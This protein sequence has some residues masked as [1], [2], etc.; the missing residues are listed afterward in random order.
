MDIDIDIDPLADL[1][2]MNFVRASMIENDKIKQHPVGVYFQSIPIDMDSGLAAIPYRHA[3]EYGFIKIDLLNLNL[4]KNFESRKE[5]LAVLNIKPDWTLLQD[6]TIVKRLFHIKNHF[7]LV[8]KCKPQSVEDL[9][10]I[11][12]LIRP[13]KIKFIDKYLKSKKEIRKF[14]YDKIDD[15]DLRKS[16][17]IAYALNIVLQINLIKLGA[18]I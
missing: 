18:D 8:S 16:H 13:N 3:Q 7:D 9:A 12:A 10:D 2:G 11:L 15:S 6:E 5:V 17:A 14:L 1:T 4:L